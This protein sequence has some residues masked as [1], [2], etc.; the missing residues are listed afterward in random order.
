MSKVRGIFFLITFFASSISVFAQQSFFDFSYKSFQSPTAYSLGKYG[1]IPVSLYTGIPS[2]TVPITTMSE[3]SFSLPISMEY[4]AGGIKAQEVASWVGLGWS[5][6]SGG[7]ITRSPRGSADDDDDTFGYLYIAESVHNHPIMDYGVDGSTLSPSE[8]ADVRNLTEHDLDRHPVYSYDT[9]PDVFFFNFGEYSGQFVLPPDLLDSGVPDNSITIHTIPHSN[10][11]IKVNGIDNAGITGWSITDE[12]GVKYSFTKDEIHD[13]TY[14]AALANQGGGAGSYTVGNR[15]SWFLTKIEFPNSSGA[16]DLYYT[17]HENATYYNRSVSFKNLAESSPSYPSYPTFVGYTS[18]NEFRVSV[19]NTQSRHQVRRLERIESST[20]ILY[21]DTNTT[22]D[23][24]DAPIFISYNTN[25]DYEVYSEFPLGL[26]AQEYKLNKIRLCKKNSSGCEEVKRW[27]FNYGYFNNDV[28]YQLQHSSSVNEPDLFKRLKLNSVD[29]ADKLDNVLNTYS[30]EYNEPTTF[31]YKYFDYGTDQFVTTSFN[32]T[33]PPYLEYAQAELFELYPAKYA[34]AFDHWGYFNGEFENHIFNIPQTDYLGGDEPAFVDR[35]PNENAMKSGTLKRIYYPTGGYTE[36]DFEANSYDA[37]GSSQLSGNKT[38]GGL[39]IKEIKSV[40]GGDSPP[41]IKR[42]YYT[43]GSTTES[44][45]AI[46]NEH[47]YLE[48]YFYSNVGGSLLLEDNDVTWGLVDHSL[49]P[50]GTSLGGIVGYKEVKVFTG[51][52]E[53]YGY[54]VSMFTSPE[55]YPDEVKFSTIADIDLQPILGVSLHDR[56]VGLMQYYKK[57]LDPN[58]YFLDDVSSF[59]WGFGYRSSMDSRRGKLLTHSIYNSNDELLQKTTNEYYDSITEDESTSST[60]NRHLGLSFSNVEEPRGNFGGYCNAVD[61]SLCYDY[62]RNFP[63]T[64]M[65]EYEHIS[66]WSYLKKTE[67]TIYDPSDA[68]TGLTTTVRYEHDSGHLQLVKEITTNSNE[69]DSLAT[70]Y[71]YAHKINRSGINYTA[72]EALNML[73]YPYSVTVRNANPTNNEVLSKSWVT[74]SSTISGALGNWMPEEYL[75]WNEGAVANDPNTS[76]SRSNAKILKYDSFGNPIE[77]RDVNNT[78]TVYVQS[79]SNAIPIGIFKNAESSEVYTYSFSYEGDLG[80]WVFKNRGAVGGTI[81]DVTNGKLR[82][83]DDGAINGERDRVVYRHPTELSGTVV[84]EFDVQVANSD[85]WGLLMG[86]G[87]SSWNDWS[88]GGTEASVWASIKDEDFFYYDRNQSAYVEGKS[89]LEI[90]RTYSFKIIMNS[91]TDKVDYYIDGELIAEGVIYANYSSSGIQELMLANFG[92]TTLSD[93]WYIDNVRFYREGAE[94]VSQEID[95]IFG[96]PTSIKSISGNTNRFEYDN[97]GRLTKSFNTAGELI[98]TINYY[99]S[100]LGT[101]NGGAYNSADP[102]YV[103]T[104]THYESNDIKSIA[105]SDGLGR[106]IQ[107]QL[108]GGGNTIV[109]ETRYDDR[110]LPEVTSRPVDV[111][112]LNNYLQYLFEYNSSFTFTAPGAPHTSSILDNEYDFAGSEGNRPYSYMVYESSPLARSIESRIPGYTYVNSNQFAS[113]S[114]YGLNTDEVYLINGLNWAENSLQKVVNRDPSW[115]RSI[116]YTDGWGRIILSGTDMDNSGV[117]LGILNGSDLITEYSYDLLG[118]LERIEDP[119]G[120]ITNYEYDQLGQV[121]EKTLPDWWDSQS[122]TYLSEEYRYN[123]TGNLRFVI[124]PTHKEAPA[125]ITY[126]NNYGEGTRTRTVPGDG[127]LIYDI[128][129]IT[130]YDA[131]FNYKITFPDNETIT[132]TSLNYYDD[133]R[134]GAISVSSGDYKTVLTKSFAGGAYNI[135]Q[136]L[137]FKP[138]KFRYINYDQLGRKVEEGEYYGS[139]SFTSMDKEADVTTDKISMKL[140]HYDTQSAYSGAKNT[141]GKIA[142]IQYRDI[143]LNTWG[144]TWYSYNSEGQIDWIV[145]DIPGLSSDYTINYEYDKSDRLKRVFFDSPNSGEDMYYWYSYDGLGR[146][147][148]ISSNTSDNEGGATR[149]AEYSYQPDGQVKTM[150]L[151]ATGDLAQTVDYSYTVQG[152]LDQINGGTVSASAKADRF[153]LTLDYEKNGNTKKQQWMQLGL[154]TSTTYEYNY[155][156]NNANWLT[157]ACF[158]NTNCISSGMSSYDVS[159]DYDDNGNFEKIKRYDNTGSVNDTWYSLFIENESNRLEKVTT[160]PQS[161]IDFDLEYDALGNTKLHELQGITNINYDSNNLPI[162]MIAN[163]QTL[164]STY[165]GGSM[166]VKKEL[167]GGEAMYYIRGAD[168][169]TIAVHNGSNIVYWVLPGGI[170]II[171]N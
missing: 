103:E 129:L 53:N 10:L 76:I 81:I 144:N 1:E 147:Q 158:G 54:E 108:R 72:M 120:L 30:L 104:I 15:I 122:Q 87:G 93:P 125:A 98:S 153:A 57:Y 70:E 99:Y 168:G 121:I 112:G 107:N 148:Y 96:V 34:P 150:K 151:G 59:N 169:E 28:A 41:V 130:S 6:N 14:V 3:G 77:V 32:V 58:D 126:Y 18:I 62:L 56:N 5:L 48:P 163:G 119:R 113:T 38:A 84:W 71:E 2:I 47:T 44:S 46:V 19:N 135:Y 51:T 50:L 39:R 92:H 80:D 171:N 145:Q 142:R 7:V 159:Y 23:R 45:G 97:F 42:Y 88:N 86:S 140:Y 128:D 146:I 78:K 116:S 89:N 31:P 149:E 164:R 160:N 85:N 74:W 11:R 100:V 55:T 43:E 12:N 127:V 29:I 82:I 75:V 94:V 66:S 105:Y 137:L 102:N 9:E 36:F 114:S 17:D 161:Q 109:S 165:D 22:P 110:G 157:S 167:V 27:N 117:G 61:L 16:I 79:E 13:H 65:I 132:S 63:Q 131:L 115:H 106:T 21:F 35:Q 24:F 101:G 69:E 143:N 136:D 40:P 170:G 90:G 111:T 49:I 124:T 139:T 33:L 118:R 95:P 26:Q 4:H 73:S 8:K 20:H 67:T 60:H 155:Y 156:Y 152:W 133:E 154:S 134:S 64:F 25:H 91:S 166:R 123:K 162:Q 68:S 141:K 138:Y 52:N 37:V 83:S